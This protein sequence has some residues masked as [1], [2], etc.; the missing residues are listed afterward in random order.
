MIV[1]SK[2]RPIMI[3][4]VA[5]EMSGDF[6]GA[7]LIKELK[8]HLKNVYF[9]GIGGAKMQSENMQSWYNIE[10]LSIIGIIE[11]LTKIPKI[12]Y[13][14]KNIIRKFIQLK[15]DIFIGIDSPDFNITLEKKLK[16]H[17]I[18]TVHYVSPSI[19]AWR[20]NRIFKLKKAIDKILVLLP[21]EKK[22]YDQYKIP[23]H[24]VGH[25]LADHIPLIPDKITARQKL[26]IPINA[27]CLV[28]LPGSR[29]TEIKMLTPDFLTCAK[30]LKYHYPDL[31]ILVPLNTQKSIKKFIDISENSIK[32][33]VLYTQKTWEIIMA[34]D[35]A[36]V[37]SGT[38][39][40][41]CMLV[42]CPMVVAY[43]INPLT[44]M[45]IK[46]LIKVP[47]ISLPNLLANCELVKEFIQH[48]CKPKKLTETLIDLLNNNNTPQQVILKNKFTQIHYYI[49]CN[50][51][52]LAAKTI[53][54]LIK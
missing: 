22:I 7:G 42:K 16:A 38:A 40:L 41:E 35:V 37:A 47:W 27:R 48:D 31:K 19:W 1:H 21:F 3:G 25:S 50:A 15:I 51:N 44:F 11:I 23:C 45:L 9:F 29:I 33:R 8:K 30:L 4:M 20:K 54:E 49:K 2:H 53:L 32:C 26:G 17:G 24:F 34:A 46:Y 36:L 14:R 6:L 28:L 5:G 18:H 52:K 12:L 10:E 39:T 13:I 43:R